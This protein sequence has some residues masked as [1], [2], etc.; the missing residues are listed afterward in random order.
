M[1]DQSPK[2]YGRGVSQLP[3]GIFGVLTVLTAGLVI[4]FLSQ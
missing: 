4:A 3:S 1:A 2:A